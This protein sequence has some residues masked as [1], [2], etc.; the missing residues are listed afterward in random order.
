MTETPPTRPEELA[1]AR[2]PKRKRRP[3]GDGDLRWSESRQRW[4]AEIT[5]GYTPAGK[6]M[7]RTATD[8][9]KRQALKKLHEKLRDRD[10]GLPNEDTR[11]TVRYA[12]ENWL[13][14]GL[15]NRD[16]ETR[17]KC[18]SLAAN[19]I[20]PSLG[21]R[22]LRELP[23]DDVDA[24][25]AEKAKH[26]STDTLRQLRSILKRSVARAQAR[27]KVKRNVVLLCD[28]PRGKAGRPSKSLTLDQTAAVLAAATNTSC[29]P[30][31]FCPC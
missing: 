4:I 16:A 19:H 27:D 6:R 31:S 5:I 15:V 17:T 26:L 28:V 30:T 29:T 21:A 10:D 23:A 18:Q 1:P 14:Y 25:L 22:K 11:Y 13:E 24:W 7:V 3:Q 8:K 2:E 20:L 9:N 12:V